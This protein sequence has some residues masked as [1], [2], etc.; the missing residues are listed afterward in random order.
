MPRLRAT[1]S[2]SKGTSVDQTSEET[3]TAT[4][5][6]KT[7]EFW[8]SLIVS[9]LTLLTGLGAIGPSVPDKYR[10]VI[11]A[12]ALLAAAAST[13]F[14]ALSRGKTKAAAIT[15]TASVI[16]NENSLALQRQVHHLSKK[17]VPTSTSVK[18]SP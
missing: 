10:A 7:T 17:P 3:L 12:A 18:Q 13:G 9:T 15:A 1:V 5:G 4:A 6:Y 8:K 16:N 2:R 14:Y 11:D